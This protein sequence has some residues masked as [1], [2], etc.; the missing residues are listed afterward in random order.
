MREGKGEVLAVKSRRARLS[1]LAVARFCYIFAGASER[2][3][4][5][6]RREQRKVSSGESR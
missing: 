4:L 3:Q 1:T 6:R 5:L 2:S